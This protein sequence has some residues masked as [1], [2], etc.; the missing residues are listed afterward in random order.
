MSSAHGTLL[1]LADHRLDASFAEDVAA[2][3]DCRCAV[4]A[5]HHVFEADGTLAAVGCE[6]V[7]ELGVECAA[8][9]AGLVVGVVVVVV[10]VIVVVAA[11]PAVVRGRAEFGVE[12]LACR[13]QGG[14]GLVDGVQVA[15]DGA[16]E[17][18]AER[19]EAG[20]EDRFELDED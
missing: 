17:V 9:G 11:A 1:L 3:G 8:E 20:G 6:F 18:E 12:D 19:R 10:V 15:E 14:G 2:L 7:G 13:G 5:I 4:R 16:E